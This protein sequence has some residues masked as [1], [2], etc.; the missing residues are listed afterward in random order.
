MSSLSRE[1]VFLIL[2]FLDEEKFKDTVHRY[3]VF[4]LVFVFVFRFRIYRLAFYGEQ[5]FVC[6]HVTTIVLHFSSFCVHCSEFFLKWRLFINCS[7]LS[8][9]L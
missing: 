9:S 2:Q 6:Q 8:S 3:A 5:F 1:L 4:V 7:Q